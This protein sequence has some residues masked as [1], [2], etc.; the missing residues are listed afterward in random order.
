MDTTLLRTTLTA[1]L[2]EAATV[3]SA[4]KDEGTCCLDNPVLLGVAKSDATAVSAVFRS[5]GVRVRSGS[6]GWVFGMPGVNAQGWPRTAA[7]ELVAKRL[8]EAGFTSTVHY[9]MD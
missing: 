5:L 6:G 7:A 4:M 9:I 8:A 2:A 1:A 3:A